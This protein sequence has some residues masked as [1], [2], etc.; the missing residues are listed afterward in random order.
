MRPRRL[1]ADFCGCVRRG[2]RLCGCA[3][4]H[5][6]TTMCLVLCA[7]RGGRTRVG[8]VG[9]LQS[10]MSPWR[11]WAHEHEWGGGVLMVYDVCDVCNV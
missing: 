2:A 10:R 11:L 7:Q 5:I 9:V 3:I 8:H 1:R 4:L 6:S